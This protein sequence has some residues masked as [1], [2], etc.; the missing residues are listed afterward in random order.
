VPIQAGRKAP[1]WGAKA[2]ASRGMSYYLH[3]FSLFFINNKNS[4]IFY[5]ALLN[6]QG[7]IW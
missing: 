5:Y 3:M 2:Q 6:E 4:D 1:A 7:A